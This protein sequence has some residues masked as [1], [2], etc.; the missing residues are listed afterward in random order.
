[1]TTST[2]YTLIGF[3][4]I[5]CFTIL[6]ILNGISATSGFLD[7]GLITMSVFGIMSIFLYY[8]ARKSVQ[9]PNR[10]K[11][12]TLTISNMFIRMLVSIG[13]ILL[14][15]K[16]KKPESQLF[17]IPFLAT[18]FIFTIFETYFLLALSNVKKGK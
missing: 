8:Y 16:I 7:M 12:I 14:Y 17:V 18:Y 1:M 4:L 2:F 5:L 13:L 9:N 3:V 6:C 15:F 11:F 10:T